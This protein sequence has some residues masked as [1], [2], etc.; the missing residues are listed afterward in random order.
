M[1]FVQWVVCV[2]RGEGKGAQALAEGGGHGAS[3]LPVSSDRKEG[4]NDGAGIVGGMNVTA[5]LA[6]GC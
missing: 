2:G 3:L 4:A 6:E 1:L 5:G